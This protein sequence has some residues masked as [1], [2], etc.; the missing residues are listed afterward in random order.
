M[1]W[2]IG[3]GRWRGRRSVSRVGSTGRS[4]TSCKARWNT[5]STCRWPVRVLIELLLYLLFCTFRESVKVV[6]IPV[7]VL[8]GSCVLSSVLFLYSSR[9]WLL[10]SVVLSPILRFATLLL[11]VVR[12]MGILLPAGESLGHSRFIAI[13]VMRRWTKFLRV[14]S[15]E[16]PRQ[17]C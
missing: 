9:L 5:N 1:T 7:L 2:H 6:V 14:N 12:V 15:Q 17:P 4:C 13:V 8:L 3:I 11:A 16:M 10:L